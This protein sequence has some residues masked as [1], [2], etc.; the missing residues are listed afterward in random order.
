MQLQWSKKDNHIHAGQ[1]DQSLQ[2]T[3]FK[4]INQNL[5]NIKCKCTKSQC[6]YPDYFI[7]LYPL[8]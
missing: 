8:S 3:K 5:H 4:Q 7:H 2:E 6:H 1:N